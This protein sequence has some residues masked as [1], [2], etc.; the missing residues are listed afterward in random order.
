MNETKYPELL[1]DLI[2][3][4]CRRMKAVGYDDVQ[5]AAIAESVVELV[6]SEW[7][8]TSIYIPKAQAAQ[9]VVRDL[10]IYRRFNGSNRHQL[11]KDFGLCEKR[12]Y[13]IYRRMHEQEIKYRQPHLFENPAS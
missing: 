1:E 6:R 2:D 7:G 13:E 3:K 11:S 9:N 12:I 5:A 8:G 10:E 4:V